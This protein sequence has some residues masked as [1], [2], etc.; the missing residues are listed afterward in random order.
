MLTR[1]ITIKY[2]ILLWRILDILIWFFPFFK[3]TANLSLISIILKLSWSYNNWLVNILR[4]M[5]Q[6]EWLMLGVGLLYFLRCFVS[7]FSLSFLIICVIS[8]ANIALT[9]S[10]T[11]RTYYLSMTILSCWIFSTWRRTEFF[12]WDSFIIFYVIFISCLLCFISINLFLYTLL[13]K[14]RA[15]IIRALGYKQLFI[16]TWIGVKLYITI[17]MLFN[18]FST[19]L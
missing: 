10:L 1:I 9:R 2:Y 19:M 4:L 6:S 16:T 18:C 3:K 5:I 13:R 11:I 17:L 12:I 7:K 15:L 14:L 8:K